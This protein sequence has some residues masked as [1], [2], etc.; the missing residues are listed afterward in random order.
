[1][2]GLDEVSERVGFYDGREHYQRLSSHK[3]A[4]DSGQYP[5]SMNSAGEFGSLVQGTFARETAARFSP[6]GEDRVRGRA[7]QVFA[8]EVDFAH[9]KCPIP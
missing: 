7:V 9:K 4:T 6:A 8:Y 5:T 2:A 1:M 3:L